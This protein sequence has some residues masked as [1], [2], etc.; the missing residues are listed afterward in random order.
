MTQPYD[1]IAGQWAAMRVALRAQDRPLLE[2]LLE[3]LP[4]GAEVLDLG[5]GTGRPNAEYI[6]ARG[7]RVTGVDQSAAMLAKAREFLPGC[8]W[9]QAELD[10]V[11]LSRGFSAVLCWDALFHLERARHGAVLT[12]A[13]RTLPP[14]GR[15]LFSTGGSAHPPFRDTM[16]GHEFFYDAHPPAEMVALT[17]ATGFRVL[18]AEM[19]DPPTGGRDKGKLAILAEKL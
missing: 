16:W 14:G 5:C 19:V 11:E 12:L 10:A 15:L 7:Y 6:V 17:D 2:R 4:P 18:A 9:I 1:R 8:D 13:W 3:G